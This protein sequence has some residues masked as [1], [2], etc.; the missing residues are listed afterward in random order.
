MA[1]RE[2]EA[3]T[4]RNVR[5]VGNMCWEED[6]KIMLRLDMPGVEKNDV[7]VRI[8][9]DQLVIHGARK[10]ETEGTNYVLRERRPGD[11]HQV[12]TLDETVDREKIDAKMDKGVLTLTLH[13]QEAVKPRKID[14][15]SG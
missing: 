9:D 2:M 10:E 1:E 5:P 3:T 13:L 14:V 6:G 8:E 4:G 11:F 7:D 12:F 15:K